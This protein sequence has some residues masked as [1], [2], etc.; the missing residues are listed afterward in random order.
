MSGFYLGGLHVIT[1]TMVQ[2]KYSHT[3]L[4]KMALTGGARIIQYR[5]KNADTRTMVYEARTIMQLCREHDA[6]LIINDRLDIALASRAH[7]LHLGQDDLPFAVARKHLGK[8]KILGCSA[9]TIVQA[10]KA[11]DRG[12][13][14]VGFGPVY[15]T[16]S[17]ADASSVKG[18]EPLKE[19]V[20][21]VELPIIAIGGINHNNIKEVMAAGAAGAAVI[22]AICLA[23]DPMTATAD[24]VKLLGS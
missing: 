5:R 8:D 10:W 2:H 23:G 15:P 19:I 6:L 22:G 4:A 14:Y 21:H 16:T 1:D 24:F 7:G 9:G 11:R 13:D 20:K 12:A 17:K 3:D 18:L